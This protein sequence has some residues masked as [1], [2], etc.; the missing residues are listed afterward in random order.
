MSKIY[1]TDWDNVK[2]LIKKSNRYFYELIERTSPSSK[3][4]LYL[5][6]YAYGDIIGSKKDVYLPDD[7]GL[8]YKLGSKNTPFDI[9]GDLGYGKN[10]FPLGIILEN[11]C[12]WFY[13]DEA[14]KE[15]FPFAIQGEGTIFNQQII[16]EEDMTVEN[17]TIS[18]SS[19]AKS[20]FMLPYIG[21]QSNHERIKTAL[22]V[23][24]PAPKTT[25]EHYDLFRE[26]LGK[27]SNTWVSKI[28]YFSEEWIQQIKH[29]ET[30]LRVKY[31]FSENL[32]KRCSSDLYNS[33]YNDLFLT[34][35]SI[36]RYRPTP[37]LVDTA[38]YIFSIAMGQGL[39]FKPATDNKLLPVNYIQEAYSEHYQLPY[40]PTIMV[41][42]TLDEKNDS[43]YY[44]LQHPSTKINTFKI[45]MNNSTYRELVTLK[46]IL[47]SYKNSF[48]SEKSNCFGSELYHAC[49]QIDLAFYHNK[50]SDNTN[51]ILHSKN[52]VNLDER[53][54]YSATP[55]SLFSADAKFLR[56]CIKLSRNEDDP[57][58]IPT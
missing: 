42:G 12:E 40:T 36:N 10:S 29:N 6:E 45:T 41:P 38:K 55:D 47:L 34:T 9:M 35:E 26:I 11:Y 15:N 23:S 13:Q 30:W 48:M 44:S 14:S 17:N 19:G 28:V 24:L 18:V 32:R 4:P 31:F 37:F 43:I 39:G 20:L 51:G 46:N 54:N 5:A 22:N 27:S 8:L 50:P 58:V 57:G 16:F 25:A 33:F 56:G 3:L 7:N 52:M 1:K 21:S 53:F 2:D 49:N